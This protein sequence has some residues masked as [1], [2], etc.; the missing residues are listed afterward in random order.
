MAMMLPSLAISKLLKKCDELNQMP[1][2]S[3]SFGRMLAFESDGVTPANLESTLVDYVEYE[4]GME[5]LEEQRL[6]LATVEHRIQ[7]NKKLAEK[8]RSID[9]SKLDPCIVEVYDKFISMS[10][11]NTLESEY[12]LHEKQIRYK[13]AKTMN[14][15]LQSFKWK[16]VH[17]PGAPFILCT[18]SFKPFEDLDDQDILIHVLSALDRKTI[19]C[20]GIKPFHMILLSGDAYIVV[21]F[22]CFHP[23]KHPPFKELILEHLERNKNDKEY[24]VEVK[25]TQSPSTPG[26]RSEVYAIVVMEL[27]R[28]P[29][30]YAPATLQYKGKLEV[31]T[32]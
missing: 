29:L 6:L 31:V 22:E 2:S 28:K 20:K 15:A 17:S 16:C 5:T 10:I 4:Y 26:G 27:G 9:K 11:Q 7:M 8:L 23:A 12:Q 25:V 32:D 18:L 19:E 1:E 24:V 13:L 3:V 30:E 14:A 21:K